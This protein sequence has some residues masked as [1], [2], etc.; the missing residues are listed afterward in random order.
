ME[1]IMN[2]YSIASVVLKFYCS[3]AQRVGGSAEK[4]SSHF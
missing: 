1:I 2:T 3:G 4:L